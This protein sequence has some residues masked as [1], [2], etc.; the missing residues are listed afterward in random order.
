MGAKASRVSRDFEPIA[1]NPDADS[2]TTPCALSRWPLDPA[3]KRPQPSRRP[4]TERPQPE[5]FVFY[6]EKVSDLVKEGLKVRVI[7]VDSLTAHFRA[8][9]SGRGQLAD[10]QQKLNKYLHNLMKIAALYQLRI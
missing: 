6:S 2:Q 5:V 8:E 7:I 10:R 1:R 3:A 4:Q 9:F